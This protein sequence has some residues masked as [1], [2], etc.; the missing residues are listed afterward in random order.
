MLTQIRDRATGWIAW[1]IVIIISIPFALWGINEYFSGAAEVNVAIVNGVEIDQ[2]HYRTALEDQRAALAQALGGRAD[3]ELINST[4]FRKRVLDGLIERTLLTV[5]ANS[6]GYRISDDQLSE[7]IKAA[8]Q[9]QSDGKFDNELYRQVVSGYRYTQAGFEDRLRQE[10]I[11]QQVRNG[12]T[13]SAFVTIRDM[14]ELL[15]LFQQK[16]D[17]E[18]VTIQPA[19]FIDS[20]EVT[21]AD[22]KEEYDN[23]SE[24]YSTLEQMKIQ[25]V[26]LAVDELE[27]DVSVSEEELKSIYE[28]NKRRFTI[29]EQRKASHILL[30]LTADA[31]EEAVNEIRK[32]AEEL[33]AKIK[34]GGD[35]ADFAKQYSEDPGSAAEG[36]DLGFVERG[37]MV[38]AF[39]EALYELSEGAVSDPVRSEFGFHIIKLTELKP[40]SQQN[41]E[42]A[43][44]QLEREETRRQAE[45]QFL[46]QA[47][48]FRN[49]VFEQPE[50]LDA[51]AE[52]L[53]LALQTS[54]WFSRG[55]GSDIA[56]NPRVRDA[57]FSDDVYIENLN[58]ETLELDANSLVALRKLETKPASLRPLDE[59]RED[60]VAQLKQKKAR[61]QT[62][63]TGDEIL[64][65]L[66]AGSEWQAVLQAKDLEGQ[67]ASRARIDTEATPPAAVIK[68]VFKAGYPS[69]DTPVYG[70]VGLPD[71]SHVVFRLTSVQDGDPAVATDEIRE[72]VKAILE[73]RRGYD[74]FLSYQTGL[75]GGA[76]V[77]VYEDQ[78]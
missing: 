55:E 28:A 75:R 26:R 12:F 42:E 41:F 67:K 7:F 62:E 64:K 61:Q 22:V 24:R 65:D 9:F 3:P 40:Q 31:D 49:L 57:A 15:K 76:E 46:E 34:E 36:G 30:K 19:R 37:A 33:A 11:L 35:F 59:V 72:R 1:V 4:A 43:R 73:R 6:R 47:E 63:K 54:D 18:Y 32:K 69:D 39:E 58:S 52:Q 66:R 68:A 14:D 60:I 45:S 48:T 77:T 10:N 25:Y 38:V 78:L 5:D 27:K 74:S 51:V 29:P 23:N 13:E 56:A 17:F 70:D 71:G 44:E 16:R 8:P 50:T 21:D 20:V 2:N 53:G